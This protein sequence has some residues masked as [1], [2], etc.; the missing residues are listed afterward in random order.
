MGGPRRALKDPWTDPFE[1]DHLDRQL[2]PSP[3]MEIMFAFLAQ[4]KVA[5]L[6]PEDIKEQTRN[7][8]NLCGRIDFI[9]SRW[10]RGERKYV[11]M[12][13]DI[14]RE[15][16]RNNLSTKGIRERADQAARD[17]RDESRPKWG[18]ERMAD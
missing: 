7:L 8:R 12:L 1:L 16:R 5:A 10:N 3:T 4:D 13:N 11:D 9:L 6:T 15:I 17:R 2:A 14:W 18:V